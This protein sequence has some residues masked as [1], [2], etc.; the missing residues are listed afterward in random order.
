MSH[1]LAVECGTGGDKGL[2]CARPLRYFHT[3]VGLRLQYGSSTDHNERTANPIRHLK[4]VA[5][6]PQDTSKWTVTSAF[7]CVRPTCKYRFAIHMKY[8]KIDFTFIE[9]LAKEYRTRDHMIRVE[10]RCLSGTFGPFSSA[11]MAKVARA[12]TTAP[13]REYWVYVL[14]TMISSPASR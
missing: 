12:H 2:K 11:K 10:K 13:M 3:A 14:C 1:M 8:V 5:R 9:D 4:L 6:T 7:V